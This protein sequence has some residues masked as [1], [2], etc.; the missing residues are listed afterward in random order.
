VNLTWVLIAGAIVVVAALLIFRDKFRGKA[1]P[2]DLRPG[3]PL[4]EFTAMDENGDP[5]SSTDLRGRPSVLLFVRGNWCPFC[6]KQVKNLTRFYKE[7]NES[8]AHLILVTPKPLE[9]TRRVADFF[10]VKFEFW[11]DESLAIGKRLGLVQESGVPDDYDKEYGRDTL[12]P[13]S[14]IVDGKGVIRHTELS[15]FIAD[16]PDPEKLLRIVRAL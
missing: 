7:I 5:L 8:G 15:R 9:T 12:W 2:D 1:V 11:L 6:S 13:A 14:L 4:P 16:R 10:D 3:N